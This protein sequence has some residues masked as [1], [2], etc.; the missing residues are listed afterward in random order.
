M[1]DT[2]RRKRAHVISDFNDV[3]TG[4]RHAAKSTPMLEEG[5]F[6]NYRAAGLVSENADDAKPVVVAGAAAPDGKGKPA[7]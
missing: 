6:E 1:S 4:E 3:G 7:A 2:P 5:V